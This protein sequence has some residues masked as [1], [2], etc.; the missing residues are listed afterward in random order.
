MQGNL[1]GTDAAGTVALGNRTG[2]SFSSGS[3]NNMVGGRSRG[4]VTS[5]PPA[6]KKASSVAS[7]ITAC[8]AITSARTSPAPRRGN[9]AGVVL[10][11]TGNALVGN[12]YPE[13]RLGP[14][15][16][17]SGQCRA[18]SSARNSSGTAALPNN[19]GI[20]AQA[21]RT[22]IGG[23]AAGAGNLISGNT[24]SGIEISG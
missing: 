6:C 10:A 20:R 22:V 7:S 17:G 1:I 11:G 13:I 9:G 5:L 24:T 3:G 23:T 18:T 15:S 19:V 14:S 2:L 8:R 4:P 12:V 21:T 16:A